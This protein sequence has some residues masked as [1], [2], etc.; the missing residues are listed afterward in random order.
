MNFEANQAS[1]ILLRYL[2]RCMLENCNF[3]NFIYRNWS[4]KT[5]LWASNT[6]LSGLQ[7]YSVDLSGAFYKYQGTSLGKGKQNVKSELEKLDLSSI[8][9]KELSIELCRMIIQS[10]EETR[11]NPKIQ[12]AWI[13]ENDFEYLSQELID[14]ATEAAQ[15][16]IDMAED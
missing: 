5:H 10:R 11:D 9:C 13:K 14:E 8:C 7:L 12:L 6:D 15:A 1:F 4:F 16:T 3:Y 2:C